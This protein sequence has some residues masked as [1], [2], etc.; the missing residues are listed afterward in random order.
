MTMAASAPASSMAA[1]SSGSNE[2][3]GRWTAVSVALEAEEAGISLEQEMQ[4]SYAAFV[5]GPNAPR[6][7]LR[8][9]S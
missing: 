1:E 6:K 3:A 9:K 4:K 7:L 5:A 8:L 2:G